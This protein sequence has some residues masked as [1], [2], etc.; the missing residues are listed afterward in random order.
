MK[1]V[2]FVYPDRPERPVEVALETFEAYRTSGNARYA[3]IRLADAESERIYAA[4][5]GGVRAEPSTAGEAPAPS[6]PDD[7][8]A[9]P[10]GY[11]AEHAGGG[12]YY[13]FGP[14]GPIEGPSNG[15]F[16]GLEAAADV[17]WADL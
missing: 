13:L 10:D 12:Y 1:R 16:Q 9:L 17:A 4:E 2:R 3:G 11:H 14:G 5:Y 8:E 6:R 15:K 7:S